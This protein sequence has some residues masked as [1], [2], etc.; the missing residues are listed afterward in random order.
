MKNCLE[1]ERPASRL[2][3]DPRDPPLDIEPC[4]CS[5]CSRS[6]VDERIVDLENEIG[7][8]RKRRSK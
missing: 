5:T 3:P 1:C 6:A 4:L 8:L 7:Q 2:Y